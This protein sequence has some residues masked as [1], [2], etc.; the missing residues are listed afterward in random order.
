MRPHVAWI[1]V[2]PIKALAIEER[3]R[4]ALGPKGVEGD[5]RFCLIDPEGRMTN[6]KRIPMLVAIRPEFDDAGRHLA[7]H[8]ADGTNV[9]GEV[10]LGEPLE[11]TIFGRAVAARAVAGPW[12]HAL[13]EATGRPLRLVRTERDGDGNDRAEE[14]GAATLLAAESLTALAKA[15]GVARPVDPRRFRM[16]F[17]VAGVPAHTED[18]WIGRPVRVG[19][20]VV[21][22]VGNVGRCAVTTVDPVTGRSD[23]D[24][25]GAL[26]RYRGDKVT[27]EPLP[28]GVWA[29]VEQAGTVA[30]GDEVAV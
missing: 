20:A 5:R 27:T 6:A 17:G 29:R 7:L 23:L 19:G 12:S 18:S 25:L 22:P 11:I 15:A 16:L 26:A 8:F 28:F 21:V 4:V 14:R 1:H 13:S 10:S 9:A 2:A 30:V 24:T 3:Q